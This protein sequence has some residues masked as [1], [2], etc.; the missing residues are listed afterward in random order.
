MPSNVS[1]ARFRDVARLSLARGLA[2]HDQATVPASVV[3]GLI[4]Y[5]TGWDK[6]DLQGL[7]SVFSS[8]IVLT[9]D[10]DWLLGYVPRRIFASKE[11]IGEWIVCQDSISSALDIAAHWGFIPRKAKLHPASI[12]NAF[13]IA[14]LQIIAHHDDSF[15]E[16]EKVFF[17]FSVLGLNR[18]EALQWISVQRGIVK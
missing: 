1:L 13:L 3:G 6:T 12:W 9:E 15:V 2:E 16:K 4:A 17:L 14:G 8:N 10:A 7:V 11:E 5:M 18:T